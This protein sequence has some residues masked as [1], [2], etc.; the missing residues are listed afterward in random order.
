M[1]EI[2]RCAR[3]GGEAEFIRLFPSKRYDGFVKCTRCGNEGRCYSS[4]QNA[5]KAWNRR[6]NDD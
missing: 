6:V 5:V 4:K 2:K 3:C 1:A